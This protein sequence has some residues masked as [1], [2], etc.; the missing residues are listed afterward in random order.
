[1]EVALS[2]CWPA[3]KLFL[4]D[5]ARCQREGLKTPCPAGKTSGRNDDNEESIRKRLKTY[6]ECTQPIIQKFRA[7][8][9]LREVN[10]NR[11]EEAV[12]ADVAEVF[13]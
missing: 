9:K 8:N 11:D 6:T 3:G 7:M 13:E 5:L 2:R 1:M 10:S 4:S 12:F